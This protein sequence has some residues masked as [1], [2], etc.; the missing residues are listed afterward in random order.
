MDV[1]QRRKLRHRVPR[2]SSVLLDSGVCSALLP[3]V[4][5]SHRHEPGPRPT[6]W[7]SLSSPSAART[8][9]GP[10]EGLKVPSGMAVCLGLKNRVKGSLP[11]DQ[12]S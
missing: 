10:P 11:T 7:A 12:R 6:L 9:G 1:S 5:R 8:V 4:L 2:V 3:H